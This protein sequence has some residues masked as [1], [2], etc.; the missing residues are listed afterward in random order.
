MALKL[1]S[2]HKALPRGFTVPVMVMEAGEE[3]SLAENVVRMPL[4]PADQ[5]EAFRRLE[6]SARCSRDR[7]VSAFRLTVRQR[8]ALGAVSPH[9]DAGLS[10]RRTD[11]CP[12]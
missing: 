5:F 7:G 12:A 2:K 3:E 9:L 6:R 11:A 8:L 4:H 1:L 10:R